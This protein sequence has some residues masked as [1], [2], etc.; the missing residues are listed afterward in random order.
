MSIQAKQNALPKVSF[1]PPKQALAADLEKLRTK[2]TVLK[3]KKQLHQDSIG[4][5]L[6]NKPS[7]SPKSERPIKSS[8]Q[9]NDGIPEPKRTM[10]QMERV[11]NRWRD[12]A[13][14]LSGL[15][16][17]GNTCFLNSSLQCL[18]HTPALYN[19]LI[20]LNNNNRQDQHKF[21]SLTALAKIL[22]QSQNQGPKHPIRPSDVVYNIKKIGSHFMHGRQECAHEFTRL[23]MD[24][25]LRSSVN[26]KG[27][28]DKYEEAT[29]LPHR[30]FGGWTRSRVT[31]M[32][33]RHNSDT[34][35]SF[36]DMPL[37]I[38]NCETIY[39]CLQKFTRQEVLDEGNK[40]KCEKCKVTTRATKQFTIHRAPNVLSI[41]LKRFSMMGSKLSYDVRYPNTLKINRYCSDSQVPHEYELYAILVH[42]GFSV[43]SGHYYSYC[44][45]SRGGWSKFDDCTVT[46][47]SQESVLQKQPYILYYRRIS[48]NPLL[49][50]SST[51]STPKKS[52]PN[53]VSLSPSPKQTSSGGPPPSKKPLLEPAKLS[54]IG[55]SKPTSTQTTTTPSGQTNGF[56]NGNHKNDQKSFIKQSPK[57]QKINDN[58]LSFVKSSPV[59]KSTQ[60]S[61]K[62]SLSV[63]SVLQHMKKEKERSPKIGKSETPTPKKDH[64]GLLVSPRP[65]HAQ[66]EK[67]R[68][69]SILSGKSEALSRISNY[70]SSDDE[71]D[72]STSKSPKETRK[73]P[74]KIDQS[75]D[76]LVA[77]AKKREEDKKHRK[78]KFQYD[79]GYWGIGKA[80]KWDGKEND[81]D[82]KDRETSE[83]TKSSI[84]SKEQLEIDQGK[85]KKV[86]SEKK[87]GHFRPFFGNPFQ[88]E[89]SKQFNRKSQ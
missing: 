19:F 38:K 15:I 89:Q 48:P 75:E 42:S 7:E 68:K 20:T 16:N 32:N 11:N 33:C 85:M 66:K 77:L 36:L 4:P 9:I 58:R 39:H 24:S 14:L 31:C 49:R 80:P 84:I 52:P 22:R 81:L 8:T 50:R 65:S 35:E 72:V 23:F 79:G 34:Y 25:L 13:R 71:S 73:S 87:P 62:R 18:L 45:T 53:S 28:L 29:T 12:G 6:P 67:A 17:M 64:N 56:K 47:V 43:N 69:L 55:P 37:E 88:K 21:D 3:P 2:Y 41:C 76:D 26:G 46:P 51:Q 57:Q 30:I 61:I 27:K 40:Y 54:F 83:L 82:K 74:K 86:K 70:Y 63:S 44:K 59:T 10:F 1:G 78:R 60:N 5:K